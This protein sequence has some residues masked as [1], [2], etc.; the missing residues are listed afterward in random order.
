MKNS[1]SEV[2]PRCR[3]RTREQAPAPME[4]RQNDVRSKPAA[5]CVLR[6]A[7]KIEVES[8]IE[9]IVSFVG[10]GLLILLIGYLAPV[11]PS[12]PAARATE[13]AS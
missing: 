13:G 10:V 6:R 5:G 12:R 2:N 1:S 3:A 8:T 9:R 4:W 7:S 11:P